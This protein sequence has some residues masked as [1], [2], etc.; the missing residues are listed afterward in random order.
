[1]EFLELVSYWERIKNSMNINDEK[2]VAYCKLIGVDKEWLWNLINF[3]SGWNPKI[4]NPLSS[5]RGL[6][7]F[8]DSTAQELG[9]YNSQDLIDKNPTIESQLWGPV[10]KYLKQYMPFNTEQSLYMAIFYPKARTWS[11]DTEF[12]DSVKKVNPG[13]VTVGDYVNKVRKKAL[14]TLQNNS[15][16]GIL[17]IAGIS[18]LVFNIYKK[19]FLS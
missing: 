9:Y 8:M 11:L 10:W 15:I 16:V 2:F 12:P 18:L 4:K 6:I 5:A 17:V 3:E 13:I 19:G 7:Q 14:R 1:V